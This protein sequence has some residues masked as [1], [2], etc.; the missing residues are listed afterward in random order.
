MQLAPC[1]M[2]VVASNFCSV[3]IPIY[4][5]YCSMPMPK[6]L[7]PAS[8]YCLCQFHDLCQFGSS[9]RLPKIIAVCE[10]LLQLI[11]EACQYLNYCSLPMPIVGANAYVLRGLCQLSSITFASSTTCASSPTFASSVTSF[12]FSCSWPQRQQWPQ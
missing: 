11:I 8:A 6:L 4:V 7:R 10:C 2:D 12:M 9:V 5:L 1:S 3:P